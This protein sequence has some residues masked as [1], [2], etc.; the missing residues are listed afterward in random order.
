VEVEGRTPAAVV[1]TSSGVVRGFIGGGDAGSG[2]EGVGRK[3]GSDGKMRGKAA[4]GDAWRRRS[5]DGTF[6]L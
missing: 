5:S 1:A 3:H 6:C 4:G 2:G